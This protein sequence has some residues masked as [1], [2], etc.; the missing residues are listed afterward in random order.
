[1]LSQDIFHA[2]PPAIP[3]TA[4]VLTM[5]NSVI[6]WSYGAVSTTP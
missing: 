5:V 1:V 3:A 2:P 4:S 6:V